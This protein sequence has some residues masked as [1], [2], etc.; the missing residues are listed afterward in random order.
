M[1]RY[2]AG[3]LAAFVITVGVAIGTRA[4]E[5]EKASAKEVTRVDVPFEEHGY[6]NFRKPIVIVNAEGLAEFVEQVQKSADRGWNIPKSRL[7]DPIKAAAGDLK[8]HNIMILPHAEG[9]GSVRVTPMAPTRVD[10][11]VRIHIKRNVPEVGTADM[12]YYMLV[13]RVDKKVP[14]I[15]F[16]IDGGNFRPNR[17]VTVANK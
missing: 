2:V 17:T 1:T 12:A 13:Y 14:S 9:S 4:D 8:T 3:I 5:P 6:S 7:L 10:G 16:D 11:Q 15:A